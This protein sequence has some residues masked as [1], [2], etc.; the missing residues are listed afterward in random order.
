MLYGRVAEQAALAAVLDDA[1]AER[2]GA[3]VVRGQ[4]GVGKS[5]LLDDLIAQAHG[6]EVLRAQGVESES[7]LAF[8]ALQRFLQPAMGGVG[9]LPEP[10]ADALRAAF[11]EADSV[12]G[13][14][15]LVFMAALSLLSDRAQ[16]TPVLGVIDDAP[17]LDDASAAAL[18]FVARRV[19][20]DR[21]ALVFGAREGDV[22]RFDAPDLPDI[23]L[24]GLGREA[25]RDLLSAKAGR[26][27]PLEVAD[28]LRDRTGGNPLALVEMPAALEPEQLAGQTAL[29]R[30][31]PLTRGIERIYLER[32]WQLPARVQTFLLVAAAED[33]GRLDVVLRA[34]TSLGAGHADV[35]TLET[36]HLLTV[37]DQHVEL[38]HPL[39]RSAIHGSATSTERRRVHRALAQALSDPA[40]FDRRMWHFAGSANGPD[41]EVAHGLDQVA[42]RARRRGGHEAASAA[43]ERAAEL[44]AAVDPRARRLFGAALSAWLSG[45][46]ARSDSLARAAERDVVD[47]RIRADLT[48]L[49]ARIEWNTGSVQI[50]HQMLLIAAQQV[51]TIDPDRAREMATVATELACFGGHSGIGIDPA[52]FAGPVDAASSPRARCLAALLVGLTHVGRQEWAL[53]TPALQAAFEIPDAFPPGDQIV[54]P[55]LAIAGLHLGD[56]VSAQRFHGLLLARA[57]HSGSLITVWHALT[58]NVMS[59]VGT[60]KWTAALAGASEA[61]GIARATGQ[62][63]LSAFPLAWLAVLGALRSDDAFDARLAEATEVSTSHPTGVLDELIYDL[64]RWAIGLHLSRQPDR[65]LAH[66]RQ[67]SSGLVRREAALDRIE[68]AVR[69]GEPELAVTWSDEL[70]TF[71][72]STGARWAAAVAAHGHALTAEPAAQEGLFRWALE[73]HAEGGRPFAQARTELA[74]GE[75][76]R[77]HR[78]RVDARVRL[79]SALGTFEDLGAASWAERATQELRA[80]GENAQR[81]GTSKVAGLTGQELQV[82][83]FVNQGLSNKEVAAQLFLSPRTIDFHLRNVFTKLGVT[84]RAELARVPLD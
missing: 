72:Q 16:A 56:D 81:R 68:A 3:V 20:S 17:W 22:R 6:F 9:D 12:G 25:A 51:A 45:Q 2:G 27:V 10:Q 13:D 24:Q 62:P 79:R 35:E 53:A 54:L 44:T 30:E 47:D 11:G 14:R 42:E 39:V 49:R 58:R 69:A 33:S 67:I 63:S 59:Q 57:R 26:T 34:A 80:S 8:A 21:V 19:Q 15:F 32:Y 66:L 84:S 18:L 28:R 82:S 60:G 7:P 64:R 73:L 43:W 61:L 40:D 75:Y 55:N 52:Q 46:P 78:R 37:R 41:A 4:P 77:R 1:R 76:L 74:C 31:L 65:A 50:A 38:Q 23:G 71:A 29:P 5:A 70:V 36:A 83:R 48:S